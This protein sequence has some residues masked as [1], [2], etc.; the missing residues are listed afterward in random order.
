[1]TASIV[2]DTNRGS[3]TEI[4]KHLRHCDAE[5]VAALSDKVSIGSYARKIFERSVRFEA[6]ADGELIGL[7]AAYCNEPRHET[8]FITNV[9]VL[10]GWTS[11]GSASVL[12]SNCIEHARSSGFRRVA[13]E[14]SVEN[15]R[16]LNLYKKFGFVAGDASGAVVP[17]EL[18]I[19]KE[20]R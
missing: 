16:A 3:E 14:V 2:Y 10:P 12:M 1:M 17:M 15:S 6:W 20:P 4:E 11:R 9:S 5:F 7:V 19:K 13:L 8:A 18:I